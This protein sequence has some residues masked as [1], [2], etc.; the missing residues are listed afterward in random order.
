MYA[1]H[2][3]GDCVRGRPAGFQQV[4]ADFA[5]L[6]VDVGVADGRDEADCGRG[7]GVLRGDADGEEPCA[8]CGVEWLV[9]YKYLVRSCC[10]SVALEG[11]RG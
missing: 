7:E 5:R 4:E 9:C 2:G 8:T 3:G 10:V 1:R 11:G 6:E